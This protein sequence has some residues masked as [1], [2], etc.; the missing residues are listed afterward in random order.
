M[1]VA[2]AEADVL[3]AGGGV[4]GVISRFLGGSGARR[5]VGVFDRRRGFGDADFDMRLS[6]DIRSS[7]VSATRS[8]DVITLA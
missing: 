8:G 1:R 5:F 2:A 4:G 6:T 3:G 7:D